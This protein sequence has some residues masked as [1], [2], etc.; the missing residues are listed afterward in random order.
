[1]SPTDRAP[2]TAAAAATAR[3]G[4]PEPHPSGKGGPAVGPGRKLD[5]AELTDVIDLTLRTG[6]QLLTHGASAP[7]VE[8]TVERI[9]TALGC[10][11]LDILVSPNVIMAT[12][13]EGREFRTKARRIAALH[14]DLGRIARLNE[15]VRDVL[16][17]RCDARE[18]RQ[19]LD[20][21]ESDAHGYPRLIGAASVGLACASFCRLLGGDWIATGLA[22][23]AAFVGLLVRQWLA[24]HKLVLALNVLATS[25]A[26]SLLTAVGGRLLPTATPE[27]ALAAAVL[28]LIPGVPL[29]HAFEELGKGYSIMAVARGVQGL[30]VSFAI[31]LG[32]LLAMSAAGVSA[33]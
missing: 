3:A 25:L 32:L 18:L 27:H 29:I 9:G 10:D 24:A 14:V 33:L 20:A 8:Q 5:W 16:A 23:V 1:M 22:L 7:R 19:R 17:G 31:A 4:A 13:T 6:E 21:L 28:L 30:V 11:E 26:V 15:I 12:T 2:V